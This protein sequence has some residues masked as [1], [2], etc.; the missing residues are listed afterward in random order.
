MTDSF[1][2][3][4]QYRRFVEFC[5]YCE[6]NKHIGLCFGK[7]GVGKTESAMHYANW[8]AIEALFAHPYGSR[9]IPKALCAS[10]TAFLTPDVTVSPK[11]LQASISLLR[12][13]FDALV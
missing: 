2:I 9:I 13:R 1:M 5:Q 8:K 11:R 3:T 6:K 7:P 4:S 12:N 10:R